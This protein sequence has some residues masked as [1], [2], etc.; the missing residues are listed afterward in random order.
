MSKDMSAW[1]VFINC[2]NAEKAFDLLPEPFKSNLPFFAWI[3]LV[4]CL[5]PELTTAAIRKY[6]R[7]ALNSS[8]FIQLKPV[9]LG[10]ALKESK[11]HT[12]M[13]LILTPGNDPMDQIK[14]LAQQNSSTNYKLVSLGKGQGEKAKQMIIEA[15]HKAMWVVLQNCHLAKSF[16]PELE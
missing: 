10:D 7:E 13:L 15:K 5:K 6:V 9:F 4:R 2:R 3:P 12:P 14:K 11:C 16:L 8:D 1:E